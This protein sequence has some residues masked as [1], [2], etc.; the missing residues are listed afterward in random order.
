LLIGAGVPCG[1]VPG[2]VG[3]GTA[4]FGIIVVDAAFDVG[5]GASLGRFVRSVGS[6]ADAPAF[7]PLGFN[8]PLCSKRPAGLRMLYSLDARGRR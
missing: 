8:R 3:N 7:V 1:N 2:P 6:E 5:A 4:L